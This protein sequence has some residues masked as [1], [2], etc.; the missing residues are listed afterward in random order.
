MITLQGLPRNKEK[1]AR[2]VKF[3]EEVLHICDG[4]DISPVVEASLATFA[5]TNNPALEVN[6]IDMLI[7]EQ[8]FPNII[9]RLAQS[10]I[11][12]ELKAWHV[13]RVLKEDLKLELDSLEYWSAQWG[14]NVQEDYEKFKINNL[15]LSIIDLP[16]LIRTYEIGV[17]QPNSPN[18]KYQYKLS[19]LRSL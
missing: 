12:T 1:F 8:A 11:K 17:Q 4:I 15:E 3:L 19:L 18:E 16:S 10:G 7:P 13:L 6:D 5:Y 2:L 9:A 14:I